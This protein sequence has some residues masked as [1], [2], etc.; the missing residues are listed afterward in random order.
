MAE[1]F[2][3][4]LGPQV[5]ASMASHLQRAGGEAFNAKRFRTNMTKAF[6]SYMVPSTIR[7]E[8]IGFLQ[9]I[10]NTTATMTFHMARPLHL[11]P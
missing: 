1:P 7:P 6:R 2:K 4:L 9:G 11:G 3:N 8:T 5:V 10:N